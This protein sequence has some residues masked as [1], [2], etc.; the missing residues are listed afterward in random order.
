[1][2]W[3]SNLHTVKF[4]NVMPSS[5]LSNYQR[6]HPARFLFPSDQSP[7]GVEGRQTGDYVSSNVQTPKY[8]PGL[9]QVG[10]ESNS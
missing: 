5:S 3:L 10:G 4:K 8:L 1:M 9:L 6:P 7:S 2:I